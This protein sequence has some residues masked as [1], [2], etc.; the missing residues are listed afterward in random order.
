MRVLAF[1][2]LFIHYAYTKKQFSNIECSFPSPLYESKRKMSEKKIM[3]S[4]A[5]LNELF[6]FFSSHNT[7][8]FAY[9][10]CGMSLGI[11]R[12]NMWW[13]DGDVDIRFG[14]NK[15]TLSIPKVPRFFS[16]NNVEVWGD[17]WSSYGKARKPTSNEIKSI[18]SNLCIYDIPSVGPFYLYKHPYL[19]RHITNLYGPFWFIRLPF[20]GVRTE[21]FSKWHHNK[22]EAQWHITRH[23]LRQ[24]DL[25]SNNV[26]EVSEVDAYVIKDGIDI[27]QYNISIS[28]AERRDAAQQA[29]FILQYQI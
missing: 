8:S 21:L 14:H 24:M 12:E 16:L 22:K 27:L 17:P 13:E 3:E 2:F 6:Q 23:K 5:A 7:T 19:K 1:I 4:K 28:L 11:Y 20:K 10:D 26:I 18:Q 25:N 29:T 9:I 15:A